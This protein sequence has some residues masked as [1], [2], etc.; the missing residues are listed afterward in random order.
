MQ[1]MRF[2]RMLFFVLVAVMMLYDL[3][4]NNLSALVGRGGLAYTA[5][6]FDI[7]LAQAQQRLII[8][9]ILSATAGFGALMAAQGYQNPTWRIGRRVVK[10]DLANSHA[11]IEAGVRTIASAVGESERGEALIARLAARIAAASKTASG[12]STAPSALADSIWTTPRR[13]DEAVS[14]YSR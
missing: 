8:Q 10:V 1:R 9:S 13:V 6:G 7:T 11:E 2:F 5:T 14:M 3:F 4:F 12:T